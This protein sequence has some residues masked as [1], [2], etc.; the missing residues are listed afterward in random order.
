LNTI[1]CSN[2]RIFVYILTQDWYFTLKQAVEAVLQ[3]SDS[4]LDHDS[5]PEICILPPNDGVDSEAEAIDEENLAPV[6]L[7]HVCGEL[8]VFNDHEDRC[9]VSP[10]IEEK[11]NEAETTQMKALNEGTWKSK[12]QN[13][14]NISF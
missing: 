14:I 11:S 12:M 5:V 8:K 6:E 2:I 1:R 10:S 4:D 7:P 9:E 13:Q 3:D